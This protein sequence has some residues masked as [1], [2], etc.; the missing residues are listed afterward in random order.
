MTR[1]IPVSSTT[2]I[3]RTPFPTVVIGFQS[4][5]FLPSC[6]SYKA[7]PASFLAF[8]G[9]SR[10]SSRLDPRNVIFL[11]VKRI[12]TD[13]ALQPKR[14]GRPLP[15]MTR[16]L[17]DVQIVVQGWCEAAM[18]VLSYS[19]TRARLKEVMDRVVEDRSPVI[20]TRQKADAV[21]M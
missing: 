12:K 5:G 2:R 21:V 11:M 3:S 19:E 16:S 15:Q 9:N 4:G 7:N 10:M 1:K 17:L 6:T 20:I 8:S 13:T 14:Q 18:D